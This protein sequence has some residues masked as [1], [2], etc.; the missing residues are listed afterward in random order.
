MT[1]LAY[2]LSDDV[3]IKVVRIQ[4]IVHEQWDQQPTDLQTEHLLSEIQKDAPEYFTIHQ[5]SVLGMIVERRDGLLTIDTDNNE[6]IVVDLEKVKSQFV[7]M[8]GDRVYLNCNVQSDM[9]F[10]DMVGEI[11]EVT[12]IY[13][14][15]SKATKGLITNCDHDRRIGDV[16][17]TYFFTYDALD[18]NYMRPMIGDEVCID[19]IESEQGSM[20][21]RCIKIVLMTKSQRA[22]TN[23]AANESQEERSTLTQ[24][25]NGIILSEIDKAC[26]KELK[27]TT[28]VKLIVQNTNA[29]PVRVVKSFF[30]SKK[31]E[32]QVEIIRPQLH[33]SFSIPATEECEFHFRVRS[34][35]YGQSK[36]MFVV[37]FE[38]F[39]K[40]GRYIEIEVEDD[41][42]G[43][44]VGS[45]INKYQNK[46][47]TKQV[48][49]QKYDV[50]P[51]MQIQKSPNFIYVRMGMYDVPTSLKAAILSLHT[52]TEINEK[53][54]IIL[55]FF[56]EPLTFSNYQQRFNNLLYLEEIQH[57]HNMRRYDRD[58]AFFKREKEY[59]SLQV[60][61]IAETRPSL[62]LGDSV[63]A[64]NPWNK[65]DRS[66]FEGI[67]HKVMH[68]RVLLKFTQSFHDKYQGQDY[69]LEFF[70]SRASF[71]KQHHAIEKAWKKLGRDFL[72]PS[73]ITIQ[74]PQL[75]V[76][77]VDGILM[78]N[79]E[80]IPWYNGSLNKVQKE[81]IKNL[82]RGEARPM[83]YIIFGPPGTGKT[84][85]V[86]ETI[87]QICT[88]VKGSRLLVGT[89]SNSSANLL[90][91]RLIKSGALLPGE[92]IRIVGQ[93]AV[94][95]ESIPEFLLPYCATCDIS[96]EG[97]T[98]DKMIVTESGLKLRCNS[99]YLGRHRIT[100]GTCVT[101]GT[102]MQMYFPKDHFTH[103][104]I[105]ECGQC[106]E[107]E[108]LIPMTLLNRSSGQIIL[109]GD[110]MQLGPIILSNLAVDR[111]LDVSFLVRI[112]ERF[113]YQKDFTVKRLFR[114]F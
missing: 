76:E 48:W 7:P 105:D 74:T 59:L 96:C 84:I 109:A 17:R 100:I 58:R 49:D 60:E 4:S 35:Y 91:E 73:Q 93:N 112:L 52:N 56:K 3:P 69:R 12:A 29:H 13:A 26:L 78:E 21:W 99:T 98:T 19:V 28:E 63:R 5:R 46:S 14:A 32:S 114:I 1:Y 33:D 103:V 2:R 67:I 61:N 71:R 8:I 45:G 64:T 54:D 107:S 42:K 9:A 101:L 41:P 27:Q 87:L 37:C 53:L 57:F 15:R 6:P 83:P 106:V 23:S 90:A 10:V 110:P 11:L 66:C 62:V 113:P 22:S 82:L 65:S 88:K 40:I 77:L 43:S 25:K 50:I 24:N 80:P 70:F 31:H 89:P 16:D 34:K 72:F 39:V 68:D 75:D 94:E 20:S 38:N 86:V 111:G 18:L 108:A 44:A 81:A 79:N 92:F 97:T 51:G 30:M 95:R 47:Y 102:L 104:I 85:T 36:E 55:P